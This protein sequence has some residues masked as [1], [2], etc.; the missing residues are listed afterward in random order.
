M[1]KTLVI[2]E[3]DLGLNHVIRKFA[4]KLPKSAHALV[5]VPAGEDQEG[6]GGV[7][8]ACESF[9]IY[10]KHDHEERRCTI[11]ARYEQPIGE[12]LFI[13]NSQTFYKPDVGVI[14][15]IQ[16]EVG[17][18]YKIDL[19]HEGPQVL[20]MTI[21]Y[22]DTIQPATKL[23]LLESGYLFAAGD[24]SNHMIYRFTSLGQDGENQVSSSSFH[25]FKEA[26]LLQHFEALER[27]MPQMEHQH[28][29]V[30]DVMQNLACITDIMVEDLL[31]AT[32]K[33]Q[34]GRKQIYV[35]C[36]RQHNGTIR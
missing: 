31:G 3:V 12:G 5:P 4:E 2:Y 21:K 27:F 11:P 16:S 26:S 32:A 36:G 10:K 9:L 30:C 17:D 28:L 20:G 14:I 35:A 13:I 15:F 22:F 25:K 1:Q 24:C 29:E 19:D 7:I 33:G 34:Q 8:V 6:P 23:V 18:L